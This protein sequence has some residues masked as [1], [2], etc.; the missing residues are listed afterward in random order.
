ME[1]RRKVRLKFKPDTTIWTKFQEGSKAVKK[2][3]SSDKEEERHYCV[4]SRRAAFAI[5]A[6][7]DL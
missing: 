7:S 2:V 5:F 4:E 6:M 3:H 1:E